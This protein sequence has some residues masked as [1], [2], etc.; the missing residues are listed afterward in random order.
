MSVVQKITW[1][2]DAKYASTGSLQVDLRGSMTRWGKAARRV[3]GKTAAKAKAKIAASKAEKELE[4][5]PK[6]VTMVDRG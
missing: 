3:L 5:G 4:S 2:T 1:P 6:K